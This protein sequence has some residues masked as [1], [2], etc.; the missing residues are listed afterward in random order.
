MVGQPNEGEQLP[1]SVSTSRRNWRS[2]QAWLPSWCARLLFIQNYWRFLSTIS[3]SR[4]ASAILKALW[5][6]S[7]VSRMMS[8]TYCREQA[9]HCIRSADL[10]LSEIEAKAIGEIGYL[11]APG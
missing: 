8:V 1:A 4:R 6:L 2:P 3:Q 7:G 11:E 10:A 5:L 9:E